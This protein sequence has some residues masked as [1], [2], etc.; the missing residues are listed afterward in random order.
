MNINQLVRYWGRTRPDR[1]AIIFNDTAMTWGE[2]DAVSD[3]LA[4]GLAG[5]DVRR[6]DR[7]GILMTNKPEVAALMLATVKLGAI[8]VPLNF[9]LRGNELA[10]LLEDAAPKVVIA[11]GDL[12]GLLEEARRTVEFEI[13]ALGGSDVPPYSDLLVE[14]GPVPLADIGDTDPAFI[15]YTSGTTGVQKGALLTHAGILSVG[16]AAAVA[17]GLT[18]RDRVLAIAPLVYTGSGI[19]VF[20]QFVVYPGSTMVLLQDFDAER[21]LDILEDHRITATTMVPVIWERMAMLPKFGKARL[22]DFTFA[23]AGGAPVRLDLLEAFRSRGIPLT[24]V[25]GLTEASGLASSMRYEDA[26]SRPGFSGLPLVGTDIRIA[27]AEGGFAAPG[28]VGEILIKGPH[29]MKGY[30]RRPG[31]TAE[32][33]VDGWLRTGDV[34]LQDEDGFLK[35]VDRSKDMLISG[36]L[37]VYPAEIERA[38]AGV[39]GVLELAVI[40]V[41]D[42]SWGEVPLVVFGCDGDPTEVASRLATV[43]QTRLAGFKQPRYAVVNDGPLPRTFSGKLA[44]VVLRERFAAVPEHA[45]TLKR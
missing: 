29:V 25:Y 13:F 31:A 4:R 45:I 11:D 44:K 5:R 35:L 24:Q 19:S 3:A 43:S 36:G 41:P 38:L 8:C 16:Q 23:G 39:D 26:V 18:G 30:W 37:N 33:V 17:H 22:A 28:E 40:G 9:R 21:A 32:T 6:G 14:D 42:E 20:M 12:A 15:C 10:P 2:L 34:G 27:A 7:V 1:D